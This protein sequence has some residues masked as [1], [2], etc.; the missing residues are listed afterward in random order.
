MWGARNTLQ[1]GEGQPGQ[2]A[3]WLVNRRRARVSARHTLTE[4]NLCSF[5]P[6]PSHSPNSYDSWR[7][8]GT[9]ESRPLVT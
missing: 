9:Q 2:A 4:Q 6:A 5:P 8:G 7:R 1:V 3:A